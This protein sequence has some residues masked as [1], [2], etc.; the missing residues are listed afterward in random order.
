MQELVGREGIG[1]IEGEIVR[2]GLIFP[3]RI[4]VV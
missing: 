4:V 2:G 1:G 3:R